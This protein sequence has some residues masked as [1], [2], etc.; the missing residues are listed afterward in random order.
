[1]PDEVL[2]L[3]R[4]AAGIQQRVAIGRMAASELRAEAHT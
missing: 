2:P 1:L 3:E 4:L